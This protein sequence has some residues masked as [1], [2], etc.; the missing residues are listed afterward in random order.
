MDTTNR[1]TLMQLLGKVFPQLGGRRNQTVGPLLLR[2]FL[3]ALIAPDGLG[4]GAMREVQAEACGRIESELDHS[5]IDFV[6]WVRH[7]GGARR[8][9]LIEF[10][11]R[12]GFVRMS[13]SQLFGVEVPALFGVS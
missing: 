8:L 9:A 12:C 11:S 7:R 13:L 1:A 3:T 2:R 10:S 5:S 4:S 6:R